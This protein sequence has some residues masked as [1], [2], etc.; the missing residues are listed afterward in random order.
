MLVINSAGEWD[1]EELSPVIGP[2]FRIEKRESG[3]LS[4][5]NTAGCPEMPGSCVLQNSW[6]GKMA[7]QK[8]CHEVNTAHTGAGM[9]PTVTNNWKG[10][11]Q[12]RVIGKIFATVEGAEKWREIL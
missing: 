2:G 12:D 5:K 8:E 11:F 6:R 1:T 4:W 7:A 9:V 3:G 10:K